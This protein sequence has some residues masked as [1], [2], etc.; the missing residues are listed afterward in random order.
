MI[1]IMHCPFCQADDTKVIDS[2]L[3]A[4]G[5]QIKRR[6]ECVICHERFNTFEKAALMMP[7]VVKRDGRR[8]PFNIDN[9]RMGMMRAL[10][11]RPVSM[12]AIDIAIATMIQRIR[13]TSE[14][15][16]SSQIIGEMVVDA[17]FQLDEVA[18]VR[19]ASVYKRFQDVAAF[20]QA[21]DEMSYNGKPHDSR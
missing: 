8:E 3:I 17:L 9:L 10:E 13:Q 14:K 2:R 6:R 18:Y 20:R 19:F 21:L 11:K 7:I 5:E 1:L 16:I 4:E 12:D 15:E